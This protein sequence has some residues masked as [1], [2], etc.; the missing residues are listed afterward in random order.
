M[1]AES[2][3]LAPVHALLEAGLHQ[4]GGPPQHG[5]LAALALDVECL[6][7]ATRRLESRKCGESYDARVGLS[8]AAFRSLPPLQKVRAERGSIG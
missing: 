6:R 8:L 5:P 2:G 4:Q 7:E 1:D 3:L